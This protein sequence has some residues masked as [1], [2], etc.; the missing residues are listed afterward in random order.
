M[1]TSATALRAALVSTLAA[2]LLATAGS[3]QAEIRQPVKTA[4]GM[5]KGASAGKGV[6]V[7]KG[8]PFGA[9]PVGALRF[10]PAQAPAAWDGV[11]DGTKWGDVC[12]QPPAP[13]RPIGVNQ[14]TDM[15]DSPKISEDC[16]NLALW[17]GA[18]GAGEKRPVMVWFYGGA[19][20][21]GGNSMPFADGTN[22][23][24]K[25]AIVVAVNYRVGAFGFLSYPGLDATS[26]HNA[27]GNQALSDGIAALEWVKQNIAKFGGD[28]NNVTIFGQS[29]G[30]CI[31]AALVGSPQAKGLF[32]K[33]IS[34]SGAWGGL[35]AAPMMTREAAEKNS[36]AALEKLGVH[37]LA[38]LQALP[39]EKLA[40]IRAQGIIVDGWI[41]PEDLTKT[42]AD[43]RQNKVDVL[44]GS[45]ANE[46]GSFAFGPPTTAESWK[47]GA[48]QRWKDLANVGLAAYPATTDEQAKI[49]ATRPFTDGIAWYMHRYADDQTKAGKTAW[50]YQFAHNPPAAEDKPSGGATHASD[51]AYVF[52]NL[53]K[54]REVPDPSSPEVASKSPADIKLADQMASYWVNFARTGNP[55]GKGLPRWEPASKM[56]RN[57]AFLLKAD[58]KSATGDTMTNDQVKLYD[59]LFARDVAGPLGVK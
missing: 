12:V 5:I 28:P 39:A 30:A 7:F 50:L 1:N 21:E 49:F 13:T 51:L 17:T 47:A 23:A 31:S 57:Q 33:A 34:Q 43:G 48:A 6:T 2:T 54:P 55:N 35:T 22:L 38:D 37:S 46:G 52:D 27:S 19:Y 58:D 10:Q 20:A 56:A 11:R 15:P 14:A 41:V 3:A 44:I 29:A 26:P 53:D 36:V 9:A 45:N 4:Q 32:N 59:S 16:L 42:F 40:G 25:G 18:K 8:I 24:A